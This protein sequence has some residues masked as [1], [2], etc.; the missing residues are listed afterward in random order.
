M[1]IESQE[2]LGITPA[3]VTW[4]RSRAG[5]TLDEA[6]KYFKRIE[7]WEKGVASPSYSQLEM[8]A[9]KFKC[10]VAVFFFPSAPDV[11]PIEK[12]FR[13]LPNQDFELIPRTVKSFL[14][15]G[16]A[17]QLN[18]A[19]LNDGKNPADRVITRDLRFDVNVMLDEMVALVRSYLG[20]TLQEQY[21]WPSIEE[22]LE[23]WR[24]A[25][26]RAGV[27]VFKDA[28]HTQGYFGFCLYEQDFPII[29]VNN[30]SAKTRQIFT[31][32]HELAHLLFHT[33]GIDVFDD[34]YIDNL[35]DNDRK[36][37]I[38]CNSFAAKFLVPDGDLNNALMGQP[39]TRETAVLMANRF[40]VSREVIYR[41]MLDRNLISQAEYTSAAAEWAKQTNA[42]KSGGNYYYNQF[43]YLGSPY[44]DLALARFYQGRFDE[45]RLAEYL[46][47]KPKNLAV[48]EQKYEETR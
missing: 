27:F 47:I 25:F 9:D 35:P 2:Q 44:I 48:F 42:D 36:I 17:M 3:V 24:D 5:Y 32:F 14:R 23:Q 4:A 13:T 20:I 15:K 1:P 34:S 18:L 6:A 22:A 45:H 21:A 40:K 43:A 8:M 29:Y 19:E 31:L 10:P 37:E 33:S 46:N 39:P 41:K 26:A 30:T 12:S 38:I 7:A 28:F 16:Q 11:T